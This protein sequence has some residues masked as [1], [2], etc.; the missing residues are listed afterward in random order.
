M[1]G[2][3]RLPSELSYVWKTRV[4]SSV[5]SYQGL[6][7]HTLPGTWCYGVNDGTGWSGVSVV[8]LGQAASLI[9][10]F[11]LSVAT[12]ED[13]VLADP[14]LMDSVHV[15]WMLAVQHRWNFSA[16]WRNSTFVKTAKEGKPY[17]EIQP[18]PLLTHTHTHTRPKKDAFIFRY[19][20]YNTH[21]CHAFF[22]FFFNWK[23]SPPWILRVNSTLPARFIYSSVLW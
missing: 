21:S 11:N 15:A 5:V 18:H 13:D 16:S 9:C 19:N 12:C 10:Y 17:F 7:W 14:S 2:D 1:A 20:F 23:L 3:F 22:F 6:Y 8:W 4:C